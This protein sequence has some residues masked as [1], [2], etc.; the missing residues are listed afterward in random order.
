MGAVTPIFSITSRVTTTVVIYNKL[1]F[2]CRK[3]SLTV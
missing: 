3:E 2:P 1:G